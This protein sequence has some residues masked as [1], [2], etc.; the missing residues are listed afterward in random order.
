[1]LGAKLTL[2][3]IPL[4]IDLVIMHPG[5]VKTVSFSAFIISST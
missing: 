3:L 2:E 5:W 4:G 1:M